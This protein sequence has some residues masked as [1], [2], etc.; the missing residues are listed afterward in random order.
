MTNSLP[1]DPARASLDARGTGAEE[2][3]PEVLEIVHTLGN[4]SLILDAAIDVMR[5][6]GRP[7]DEAVLRLLDDV[8]R[9]IDGVSS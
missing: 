9:R 2:P 5:R 4:A 7:D 3:S 1:N 8:Q 6:R